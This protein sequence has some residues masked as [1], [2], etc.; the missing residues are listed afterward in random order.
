M[1]MRRFSASSSRQ[2]NAKDYAVKFL[3]KWRCFIFR[4]RRRPLAVGPK[5]Y[6]VILILTNGNRNP[7]QSVELFTFY[8]REA[9]WPTKL[10]IA[11]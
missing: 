8:R 9:R 7:R 1:R 4:C 2:E 5:W 3:A 10:R 6:F 11:N